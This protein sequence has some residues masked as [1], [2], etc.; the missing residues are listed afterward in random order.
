MQ[1][2]RDTQLLPL[3]SQGETAQ[4]YIELIVLVHKCRLAIVI[5]HKNRSAL[6][7]LFAP[8]DQSTERENSSKAKYVNSEGAPNCMK[9]SSA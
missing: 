1:H 2:G 7:I 4:K 6:T 8:D 5:A 3:T 9:Y